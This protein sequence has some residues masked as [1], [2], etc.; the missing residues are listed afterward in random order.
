MPLGAPSKKRDTT[1]VNNPTIRKSL[2]EKIQR[3]RAGTIHVSLTIRG[4]CRKSKAMNRAIILLA[5]AILAVSATPKAQASWSLFHKKQAF[6]PPGYANSSW[7]EN[8][9]Y[10][11][12]LQHKDNTTYEDNGDYLVF[13][14]KGAR[15]LWGCWKI[16]KAPE[17]VPVPKPSPKVIKKYTTKVAK[18][19]K[20]NR[21]NKGQTIAFVKPK[22]KVSK[23]VII[24]KGKTKVFMKF[25]VANKDI[26]N[27]LQGCMV[28]KLPL[29][30]II[31]VSKKSTNTVPVV[32][33]TS[34]KKGKKKRHGE[35]KSTILISEKKVLF[36]KFT[37]TTVCT[38]LYSK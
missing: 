4:I 35:G 22:G 20:D 15:N 27:I 9:N 11:L 5:T 7:Q 32:V 37:K 16:E 31:P 30:L 29:P 26:K 3:G 24:E 10:Q 12:S 17:L 6:Y 18:I 34:C 1:I 36:H 14:P 23:V 2:T 13:H 38:E 33:E 25:Q 21:A 8:L 19:R 28:N